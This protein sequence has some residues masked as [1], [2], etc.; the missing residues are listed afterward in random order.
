ME[1]HMHVS[2]RARCAPGRRWA[3]LLCALWVAGARPGTAQQA[4][5]EAP[6]PDE[7]WSIVQEL[8]VRA[9]A[10]PEEVIAE[11]DDRLI[12]MY[13]Q[14]EP[15]L[16]FLQ[17]LCLLQAGRRD[18]ARAGMAPLVRACISRHSGYLA[19]ALNVL[20]PG[21]APDAAKL[22][23]LVAGYGDVALEIRVGERRS[24][25]PARAVNRQTGEELRIGPGPAGSREGMERFTTAVPAG[26][27]DLFVTYRGEELSA[28]TLEVPGWQRLQ[29]Q[30][31]VEPPRELRI[32]Q[33]PQNGAL[34]GPTP[35][36]QW[37]WPLREG[38]AFRTELWRVVRPESRLLIWGPYTTREQSV[39]FNQDG[40]ASAPLEPGEYELA[41]WVEGLPPGAPRVGRTVIFTC[42]GDTAEGPAE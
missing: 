17:T 41:V 28:G 40:T 2:M 18:E 9:G 16:R 35:I 38:E 3:I 21:P 31:R 6:P 19:E 7:G 29:K 20:T 37:T 25:R 32:T 10:A 26:T 11:V 36:F 14:Q 24:T 12:E 42:P 27:Y 23:R 13:P 15:E 30:I 39:P 22:A 1:D 4:M 33:P 8:A 5:D 34:D